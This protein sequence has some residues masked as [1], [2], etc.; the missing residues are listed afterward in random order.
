MVV[1]KYRYLIIQTKL[2]QLNQYATMIKKILM[3]IEYFIVKLVNQ[4]KDKGTS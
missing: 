4:S 1:G 3:L 2:K